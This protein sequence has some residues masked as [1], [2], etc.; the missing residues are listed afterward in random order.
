MGLKRIRMGLKRNFTTKPVFCSYAARSN[1]S[2]FVMRMVYNIT[3]S[4]GNCSYK[5]LIIAHIDLVTRGPYVPILSIY[6]TITHVV[7]YTQDSLTPPHF[8]SD[9]VS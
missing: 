9:V 3:Y 1:T 4:V 8:T 6:S 7:S 2:D 5:Y